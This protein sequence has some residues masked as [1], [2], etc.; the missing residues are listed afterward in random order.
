MTSATR[1]ASWIR[2]RAALRSFRVDHLKLQ[3]LAFYSYGAALAYGYDVSIGSIVFEPW[4][5]GPVSREIWDTYKGRSSAEL[6]PPPLTERL[7]TYP[8]QL[9]SVL[10]AVVEVY[11]R[12][13][14]WGIRCESHLEQPWVTAWN[15]RKPVIS[16]A[17]VREHFKQKLSAGRVQ[18]PTYLGGAANA[19]VDGIP[20]A[21][22][23]SLH[24]MADALRA[25]DR[26]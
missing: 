7:P 14:P 12:L 17:E 25:L 9:E 16:N 5:H 1:L 4:K 6:P 26:R 3:K 24:E 19:A 20:P 21:R 23:W 10:E 22:F 18:L 8:Q 11:G 2:V 15:A 13:S